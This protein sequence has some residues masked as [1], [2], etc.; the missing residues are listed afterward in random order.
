MAY[1]QPATFSGNISGVTAMIGVTTLTFRFDRGVPVVINTQNADQIEALKALSQGSEYVVFV[2]PTLED[3]EYKLK[4][5]YGGAT[6]T[7]A[8][9]VA[10]AV[11]G[12]SVTFTKDS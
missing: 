4:L 10:G 9:S 12:A 7:A 11:P 8:L 5:A 6:Y 1:A 3:D 2:D